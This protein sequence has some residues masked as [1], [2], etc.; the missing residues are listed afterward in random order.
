MTTEKL[1]VKG[2]LVDFQTR[3]VGPLR[4]PE[5]VVLGGS[6]RGGWTGGSVGEGS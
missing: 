4:G 1:S 3:P 2:N 5:S 6:Q